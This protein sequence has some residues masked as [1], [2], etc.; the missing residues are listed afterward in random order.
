MDQFMENFLGFK[1]FGPSIARQ[2]V[3]PEKIERFRGKLPNKLLEYWQE[4]GWCGYA[5]GLLWTVDPDEWEDELEAWVGE[6]DFM[7]R[8]AYYVIARTAFGELIL[9]GEST[10]QSLKV[11][12]PYGMIFPSF[13]EQKFK[14]RGPDLAIQLFFSTC[15]KEAFDLLD[16]EKSPLFERALEKLGPL[17]HTTM[18]GFVPALALGGA[19]ILDRLQKLDA[20]VHLDILSQVT[21]LQVMR[22]IGQEARDAGLM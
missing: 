21:E 13:D 9:W 7:E 14:K 1:E 17:D 4:Y 5:K 22:D 18:Y 11:I 6:T 2:D 15:S 12:T 19:P 10:G 8:D 16:S 3:P 20:H